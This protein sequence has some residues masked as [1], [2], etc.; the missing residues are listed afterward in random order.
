M[1]SFNKVI[2]MGNL[3]HDPMLKEMQN[4]AAVCRLSLAVSRTWKAQSGQEQKETCFVDVTAFDKS[5]E[6][7]AKFLRKGSSVLVEG[8]LRQETWEDKNGGGKRS[9]LTVV[10]E[11]VRFLSAPKGE[12]GE[13]PAPAPSGRYQK[14][15]PP[16]PRYSRE[17][18]PDYA[19]DNENE[20]PF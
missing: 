14:P 11:Q 13:R 17:D 18:E 2:L 1:P 15:M 8:R 19:D 5:A 7:C 3:T 12:E 10:A 4:G 6:N 20:I 16:K 9:K